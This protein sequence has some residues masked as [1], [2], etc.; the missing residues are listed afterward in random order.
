METNPTKA[1][2]M[3]PAPGPFELPLPRHGAVAV[4]LT[5]QTK[6]AERTKLEDCFRGTNWPDGVQPLIP[7]GPTRDALVDWFGIR[8]FP[9]VAL[10]VDGMLLGVEHA[11]TEE[12]CTRL[13]EHARTCGV[14]PFEV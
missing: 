10:V 8:T 5:D 14:P 11:C 9:C 7:D 13:A 3:T 12:A 2:T 4:L 6:D 1:E